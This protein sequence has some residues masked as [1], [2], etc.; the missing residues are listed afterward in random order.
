MNM[1]TIIIK[2]YG[3]LL[4]LYP[5]TFRS[6]FEEQMLLDF[7]DMAT[8]VRVKG[9]LPFL[10]F[11]LHEL[12]DFPTNLVM[13]HWKEGSMVKAFHS[14]PVN[15]GLRGAVGFGVAFFIVAILD[16]FIYWQIDS[17]KDAVTEFLFNVFHTAQGPQFVSFLS[18]F[19]SVIVTGLLFGIM[20]ALLFADRSRFSQYT[21]VGMLSWFLHYA[22]TAVCVKTSSVNFYLGA[23][24]ANYLMKIIV[25][26]SVL[27]LGLMFVVIRSNKKG[28][29]RALIVGSFAYPLLRYICIQ[30]LFGSGWI[31]FPLM[32]IALIVLAM[33]YMGSVLII[34]M[35]SEDSPKIV[36]MFFVFALGYF[37][38][39]N[40][41]SLIYW[42]LFPTSAIFYTESPSWQETFLMT[43][44]A[45]IFEVP[46][47]IFVGLA[48]ALQKKIAPL[49]FQISS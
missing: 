41:M 14:K 44:R 20:I 49:R 48:L 19:V 37:L 30:L 17:S 24:R 33:I 5:S 38:V 7:S 15:Y 34:A 1:L 11:C 22:G 18:F 13:A 25:G 31:E 9:S 8:D 2:A 26:L 43:M 10:L 23:T 4:R 40:I 21:L 36:W 46:L 39:P 45:G 47:G 3:L 35:K 12:V 32:L 42:Q 16:N 27:F 29:Y 6:D 28:L